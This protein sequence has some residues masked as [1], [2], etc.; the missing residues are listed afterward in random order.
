VLCGPSGAGKSSLL[1]ALA[2]NLELRVAAV[3]GRLRSGRHTT[4]HVELFPLPS[5]RG[6]GDGVPLCP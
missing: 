4:R 6:T 3:S 2:P 1:N 5:E